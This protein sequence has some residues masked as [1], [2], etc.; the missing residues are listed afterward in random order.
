M[1]AMLIFT[2]IANVIGW[3]M[4][5]LTDLFLGSYSFVH[6]ILLAEWFVVPMAASAIYRKVTGSNKIDDAMEKAVYMLA[7]FLM[8]TGI[9][10]IIYKAIELGK[11]FPN[12]SLNR[13]DYI[14]Y[15]SSL[16]LGFIIYSAAYDVIGFFVD[17]GIHAHRAAKG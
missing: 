10:G 14:S 6:L 4:F 16:V 15:A 3:V 12:S 2:F 9:T 13:F 7:W 8:G 17:G 1:A 5:I 11:W